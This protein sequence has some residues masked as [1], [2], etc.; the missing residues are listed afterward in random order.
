MSANEL[1]GRLAG[2]DIRLG[3]N[4]DKLRYDAPAGVL[5]PAL[6][7]AMREHKV[8]LLHLLRVMPIFIDLETRSAVSL[9]D[10]GGR[11]YATDPSTAII[12][13]VA[14]IDG[15]VIIWAPLAAEAPAV[16][17]RRG[18]ARPCPPRCSLATT[19]PVPWSRPSGRA[20]PSAPT[21]H[22]GSISRS[23]PGKAFPSRPP[24]STR[25]PGPGPPACPG[26]WTG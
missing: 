3:V 12:S 18:S 25:C 13:C 23:G 7:A 4:G 5:T 2:L 24:G 9:R 14:L 20:G 8:A 10:R 6:L 21:T 1:L 11:R 17:G 16:A 15:T 19:C 22:G 26:R